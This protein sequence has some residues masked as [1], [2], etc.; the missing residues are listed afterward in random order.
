MKKNDKYYEFLNN[1][2]VSEQITDFH[3]KNITIVHF[4]IPSIHCSSCILLL[5]TLP[6]TQKGIFSSTVDF[7]SKKIWITF[8]NTKL[9]L[10]D[11]AILLDKIGYKPTINFDSIKK[12]EEKKI[13]RNLIAKLAISFFC[14]GNIMFLSIPEYLGSYED[15]W[16]KDNSYFFRYTMLLLS[17]PILILS[18]SDNIKYAILGLKKNIINIEVPIT[19]GIFVLFFW[20]CFEVIFNSRS[21]YFDSL[22]GFYLFLLISKI[23]QVHTHNKIFSFNKNYKSFYPILITK[24][25][26]KKEK[27]I[28]LSSLK[29]G[30]IIIIK[31]EEIIPSDSILI[32]GIAIID[33]SFITGESNLVNKKIGDKIYAGSKQKGKLIHLKVIK[34][35]DE[36]YLSIL[37]EKSKFNKKEKLYINSITNRLSKYFTPSV[38]IISII[39]GL[40]WYF[41]KN[42]IQKTFQTVFSILI[43]TCPCAIVL[44]APLIFG[45]IINFFSKHGFYIKNILSMEKFSFGKVLVF[46]KTGTLTN[47]NKE[48]IKFIGRYLNKEK[49]KMI[50]SL[51]R[52]SSHPLSKRILLELGN[53]NNT[54][55]IKNFREVLGKGLE[56]EINNIPIK[57]GSYKYL[58]INDKKKNETTTVAV[59]IKN[60]LIGYFLFSNYYREGIE[61]VFKNLKKYEVIILS[62]DNNILE[63]KYLKSI[64][65]KYSKIHFNQSPKDKLNYIKKLQKK[66]KNVIMFGD[67]VND[68]AALNQS[69]VGISVSDTPT[70]FFPNCDALIQTN[71]LKQIYLFLS[72]SNIS[73][74]LVIFNFIISL[75]YNIIGIF[76]AFTGKLNPL[77]AAVL[78]P[79]SS[80]SVIIF[81]IIS[82][83]IVSKKL[84]H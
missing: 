6:K 46:D 2:K 52:H 24:F 58:G 8:D 57:I 12:K 50:V 77:L 43:I 78:M 54:Y 5:E 60:K 37:W 14:F 75:F 42:N 82:T 28:L 1:N 51:L 66:K 31:N 7:I 41:Y 76:F 69:D 73:V 83:F 84:K 56:C 32:R 4:L 20:S 72:I 3:D 17:L 62:G 25:S 71:C 16:Y 23:F 59:S 45:N 68:G 35:V 70:N 15:N 65:P 27:K 39:S 61:N 36:S 18:L 80:L 33:N 67:G 10:S 79:I 40:Y 34:N 26:N 81:S 63:K 55:S 44:S 30:D 21:G 11:I 22:S 47:T 74:K 49:K 48:N 38:L 9:K 19:I 53:Y 64:L 29:K 13:D